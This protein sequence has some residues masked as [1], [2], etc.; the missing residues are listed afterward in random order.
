MPRP[1]LDKIAPQKRERVL[2]QAA[3]LFAE[4]GFEGADLAELAKRAGVAKGSLYNYFHDKQDLFIYVCR[5]GLRRSRQA[6]YGQIDP[7]WDIYQQVEHIFRR[8]VAF[9]QE[10]PEYVALYLSVATAGMEPFAERLSLEVEKHTADYLKRLI[11]RGIKQGQVRADL[12]PSLAAFLIN[13]LYVVFLVSLV[14]RHF[15]I[16]MA[17]YLEVSGELNGEAIERH[18]E[19]TIRLICQVLRPG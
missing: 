16:R 4:R 5:D 19:A 9:A 14:S 8:G 18:L 2:K 12:D 15:Q 3:R 11:E 10:H 7:A 1:T 6:V 13:S 17:E